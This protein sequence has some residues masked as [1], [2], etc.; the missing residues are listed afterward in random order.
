[1]DKRNQTI[2]LK[3]GRTLGYAEYGAPEG[4]PVFYFHGFPGSRLD[5]L[6]SDTNNTAAQLNARIIAVDRPGMGLSSFQHSREILDW[7]DDVIEIANVLQLDRFAVLGISGG[8]PYAAACAYKIPDRL[9][10]VALISGV[11]PSEAPGIKDG[12]VWT[13]PGKPSVIRRLLLLLFKMGL[14]K[15]PDKFVLRSKETF[16]EPDRLLLDQPDMAKVYVDMLREAFR[17]GIG[18][19]YHEAK[20]YT[21]PWHFQLEDITA[22]VHLWHGDIDLNVPV[23]VGHYV[24]DAIPDCQS[25]FLKDEAHLSLPHNHI[26]EIL[27]VLVV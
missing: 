11:G 21:H 9:T 13:I 19:I 22:E 3:G 26:R 27:N 18:G 7:S 12:T 4:S 24:A 20:L 25:I 6:F 5:W 15:G 10:A 17:S 8:G 23:S 16:P 1:M 2:K 14:Q